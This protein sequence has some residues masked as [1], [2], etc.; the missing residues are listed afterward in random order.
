MGVARWVLV[1]VFFGD[2]K[3]RFVISLAHSIKK[4]VSPLDGVAGTLTESRPLPA[5]KSGRGA[6]SLE[7]LASRKSSLA[8]SRGEDNGFG[9]KH[10]GK[11]RVLESRRK[12]RFLRVPRHAVKTFQNGIF[13][14]AAKSRETCH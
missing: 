14:H 8:V 7:L 9:P 6:S 12:L 3:L 5:R 1:T 11:N 4:R 2:A 10:L 13:L